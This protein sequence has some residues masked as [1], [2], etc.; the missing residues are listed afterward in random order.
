MI[1]SSSFGMK[2]IF[3]IYMRD[4]GRRVNICKD[5]KIKGMYMYG[6]ESLVSSV[7]NNTNS[8][9]DSDSAYCRRGESPAC[10]CCEDRHIGRC[11]NGFIIGDNDY[12]LVRNVLAPMRNSL[13]IK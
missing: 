11:R 6:W 4:A 9:C 8:W 3:Y 7:R 12:E 13:Q 1:I 2:S 5:S 10:S